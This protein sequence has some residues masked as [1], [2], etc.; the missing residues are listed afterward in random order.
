MDLSLNMPVA[1]YSFV[2][3]EIKLEGVFPKIHKKFLI[4]WLRI[5]IVGM[6]EYVPI[7]T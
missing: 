1:K 2:E 4:M 6:L 3:R 5:N 7:V